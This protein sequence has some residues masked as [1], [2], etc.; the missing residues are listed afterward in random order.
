MPVAAWSIARERERVEAPV[1]AEL[2]RLV[3]KMPAP[4]FGL[5]DKNKIVLRQFDD[6]K[7]LQRLVELP[8][9]LWA[10]VRRDS[11]PSFR[12]PAKAQAALAI[13]ILIYMPLRGE[14]CLI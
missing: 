14:T 2:K 4:V 12:T 8:E 10:E 6:P 9:R 13:A 3:S 11:K 5:T 1:L 7:V